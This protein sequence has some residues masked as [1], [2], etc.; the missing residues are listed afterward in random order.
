M[1]KRFSALGVWR[2]HM[3]YVLLLVDDTPTFCAV[4]SVTF[5]EQPAAAKNGDRSDVHT[6]D[7]RRE[8]VLVRTSK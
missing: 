7:L 4:K 6:V 3:M 2:M 1:V 5:H 8:D